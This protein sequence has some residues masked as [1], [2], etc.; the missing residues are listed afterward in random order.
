MFAFHGVH[1]TPVF[2]PETLTCS[3]LPAV[4]FGPVSRTRVLPVPPHGAEGVSSCQDD[5]LSAPRPNPGSRVCVQPHV[6]L[7]RGRGVPPH[8]H[9]RRPSTSPVS[10]R[11]G[12][13]TQA[14]MAVCTRVCTPRSAHAPHTSC[15]GGLAWAAH[16]G[17]KFLLPLSWLPQGPASQPL[18]RPAPRNPRAGCASAQHGCHALGIR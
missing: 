2:L 1:C 12:R 16:L 17:H 18:I 14:G 10:R 15:C 3:L 11:K 7:R 8:T 13:G 5:H 4:S 9:A 6:S